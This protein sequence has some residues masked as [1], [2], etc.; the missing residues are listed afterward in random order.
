MQYFDFWRF[1]Y[2]FNFLLACLEVCNSQ[3]ISCI[4][5]LIYIMYICCSHHAHPTSFSR[6]NFI[7]EIYSIIMHITDNMYH[8]YGVSVV[9]LIERLP[10]KWAY[11]KHLIYSPS[12]GTLSRRCIQHQLS[13]ISVSSKIVCLCTIM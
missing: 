3:S 5:F 7:S 8:D 6:N 11:R 4:L 9:H 1:E 12:H 10:H 2:M 13:S